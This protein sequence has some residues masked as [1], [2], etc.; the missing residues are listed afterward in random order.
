MKRVLMVVLFLVAMDVWGQ[1]AWDYNQQW[2][3]LTRYE[4]SGKAL[5]N[6]IAE[7]HFNYTGGR[8]Q[9]IE[10]ISNEQRNVLKYGLQQYNAR[11]ND[12]Y[13][14]LIINFISDRHYV[15]LVFIDSVT[16]RNDVDFSY[17]FWEDMSF[18]KY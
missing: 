16:N 2:G 1:S 4:G 12:V 17:L 15:A 10:H 3:G 14:V 18:R 5:F 11:V 13:I 9:Y 8:F 6:N 7:L